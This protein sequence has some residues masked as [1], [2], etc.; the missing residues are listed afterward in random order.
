MALVA[1]SRNV[2]SSGLKFFDQSDDSFA[3]SFFL[4]AVIVV[5]KFGRWVSFVCKLIGLDEKILA[6]DPVPTR[7]AQ[8]A[9]IIDCFIDDVPSADFALVTSNDFGDVL[10][11]SFEQSL[12]GNRFTL[13]IFKDPFR[14]LIVPDQCVTDNEHIVVLTKGDITIGGFEV[15]GIRPGMNGFPFEDVFRGN[16]IELSFDE[17]GSSSSSTCPFF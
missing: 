5:I 3:F 12:P 8:V 1:D 7:V 10:V 2:N 4:E 11:Q 13:A 6:Q 17:D 14:C 16:G 15:V 9:I